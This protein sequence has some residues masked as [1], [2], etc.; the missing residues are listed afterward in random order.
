[1]R[2]LQL[3]KHFYENIFVFSNRNR[4]RSAESDFQSLKIAA[5]KVPVLYS[6]LIKC[7]VISKSVD[8][9]SGSEVRFVLMNELPFQKKVAKD[10]GT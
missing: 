4:K 3:N 2:T 8:I 9:K 5:E 1:M 6:Y 10:V 7:A